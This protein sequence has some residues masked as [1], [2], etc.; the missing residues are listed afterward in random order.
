MLVVAG[1]FF[2]FSGR[3]ARLGCLPSNQAP[4]LRYAV[5][6]PIVQ[7]TSILPAT[8]PSTHAAKLPSA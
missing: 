8:T 3:K 5:C 7:R 6:A 2:A 4:P 1:G